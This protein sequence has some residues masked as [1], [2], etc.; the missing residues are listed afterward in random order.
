[1]PEHN[2]GAQKSVGLLDIAS[3]LPS[4]LAD[5]PVIVRGVVTGLL[6]RPTS[7]TSIGKVFQDRAAKLGDKVFLRFGDQ[8]LSY[9]DA[10]A[11]VNRYAAVLAARGVGRGDVVGVMLRNSPNAVLM[12]L[13]VV[14]CGAIAGM[15]NYHQR[16]DV[17]AHS[18]G[19]LNAK[20]LV[21][22]AD[23]IEAVD[24]C[25]GL[26]IEPTTIEE[27][28]RLAATAPT[29]N[30]PSASAVLAKDTAFYIFT[31]GTTGHPKASVMTHKRWLAALAA[32]GGLG[33]RLKGS[34]TLYSCLPLYHNNALTVAVGSVINAG[35]TL[36]LGKSFS[37]SRFWDEV[38]ASDATAFIYIGE[39]C[40]YLLNQPEKP[41]DRAHKVRLIAGNGLRPEIWDEFTSRFNI[42]RVCEFYAASEG[43]TAFIN[44]FNVPKS[45]GCAPMPTAYVQ[46]DTDTGAPLRGADGR[47]QRVPTGEPGLLLS[48]VTR[49]QP[50]D[51]YTDPSASEKKLVR[52]AFRDGDCWF[53]TGDVMSPQ[54]MGHAAFVDRLGDTFRWKGENV[55]TTEV[56]RALASNTAVEE[57]TVFGV[58]IPRTGGRAGMAAIKLRDGSDFDGKAIGET[59]YQELPAYAMPLFVRLVDSMEHTTTFKSRKVDLREQGYGADVE[60]PLY[61]L[62]GRDEGYVPFYAGYPDDVAGGKRPQ[63]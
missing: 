40:R 61:V 29:T 48:P 16:G 8:Q 55:A 47:V 1:M 30:P 33:L 4:L 14:K 19:L 51:G 62:A 24:E 20:V 39:I 3:Q 36:A 9:R 26:Q 59:V 10:N 53:N 54:G 63:G 49:L 45:A 27:M 46:Y 15:L 18:L 50:F 17:L 58:E 44:M 25:G 38:I 7:K 56:E 60:D 37:A 2:S 13:A 12:M 57:C 22:E 11:A 42:A 34:D 5:T 52:N 32:F 23:L 35:G 28:E 41:T 43:N 21:A 31:S 6:A